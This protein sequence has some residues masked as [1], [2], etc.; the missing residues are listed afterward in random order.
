ML[1]TD[2]TY[3]FTASL[4]V[5]AK[6]VTKEFGA[7]ARHAD[8]DDV[9]HAANLIGSAKLIDLLELREVRNSQIGPYGGVDYWNQGPFVTYKG[10]ISE[11]SRAYFIAVHDGV[12]VPDWRIIDTI[13]NHNMD[14][15]SWHNDRNILVCVAE[16]F[17]ITLHGNKLS[18]R[19]A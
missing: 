1:V 4:E 3:S 17:S 14:L 5:R 12:V 9:K 13:D 6:G 11:G 10:E 8:F 7:N 2:K 15:G 19:P 16:K 18:L